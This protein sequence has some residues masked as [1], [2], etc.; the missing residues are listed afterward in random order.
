L[1]VCKKFYITRELPRFVPILD[2]GMHTTIM[3]IPRLEL[4]SRRKGVIHSLVP[5]EEGEKSTMG[6]PIILIVNPRLRK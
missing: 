1:D 3:N 6:D 4:F 2:T 5:F